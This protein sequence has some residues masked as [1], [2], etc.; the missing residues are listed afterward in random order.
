MIV[1]KLEG[2]DTY[3]RYLPS[4]AT[5]IPKQKIEIV[6]RYYCC[7]SAS[8]FRIEDEHFSTEWEHVTCPDC[9]EMLTHCKE[10]KVDEFRE[11]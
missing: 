8:I 6:F 1:H 11:R 9:H 7:N 10:N 5:V 2:F 4:T 3:A